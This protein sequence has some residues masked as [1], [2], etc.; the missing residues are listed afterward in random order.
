MFIDI[1][2]PS[3]WTGTLDVSVC[4]SLVPDPDTLN[5]IPSPASISIVM[6]MQ[7]SNKQQTAATSTVKMF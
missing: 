6:V 4:I 7:C 5:W 2:V 1:F 3:W